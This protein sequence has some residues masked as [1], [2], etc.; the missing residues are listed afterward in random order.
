MNS[1]MQDQDARY[2]KEVSRNKPFKD[3]YVL[4]ILM[5]WKDGIT[6]IC[7]PSHETHGNYIYVSYNIMLNNNY[8]IE[9]PFYHK[10]QL[11]AWKLGE[12]FWDF[13]APKGNTFIS[14]FCSRWGFKSGQL[15]FQ[16]LYE[17][18]WH[19]RVSSFRCHKY[20]KHMI[21]AEPAV[22][23]KATGLQ[24]VTSPPHCSGELR[25]F[26]TGNEQLVPAR[27]AERS[28]SLFEGSD[29]VDI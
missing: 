4:F 11:F 14:A 28:K 2:R 3:R 15:L 19:N 22:R 26:R 12:S 9:L 23:Q 20:C 1:A 17:T 8:N 27:P 21:Q 18:K 5:A 25:V 29:S 10:K 16:H 6:F 24:N 7:L 13:T